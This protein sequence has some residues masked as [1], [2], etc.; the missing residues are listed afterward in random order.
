MAGWDLKNGIIT[1]YSPSE[2]R[3]W[4]LFNFVF[5]DSSRKRNTY[6]F[7]LIK[8]ILDNSFN[9]IFRLAIMTSKFII[10]IWITFI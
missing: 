8:S 9:E 5:S 4:S 10:I 7:G 6:K 2:E 1:E 3:I